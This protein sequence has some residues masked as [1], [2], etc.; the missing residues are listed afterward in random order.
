MMLVAVPMFMRNNHC[1]AVQSF[2]SELYRPTSHTENM[3]KVATNFVGALGILRQP[4]TTH[5]GYR[6]SNGPASSSS[7][8]QRMTG[9]MPHA[10]CW[11]TGDLVARQRMAM[12][13]FSH[14]QSHIKMGSAVV[15]PLGTS[16]GCSGGAWDRRDFKLL[17]NRLRSVGP[18][19][20]SVCT[21]AITSPWS[22]PI[23]KGP[24]SCPVVTCASAH[25]RDVECS[26]MREAFVYEDWCQTMTVP[27]SS[28]LKRKRRLLNRVLTA[29]LCSG[30][31]CRI[32]SACRSQ[33]MSMASSP[34][35]IT[36]REWKEYCT[37]F[38][39]L[40]W[41]LRLRTEPSWKSHTCTSPLRVPAANCGWERD[42]AR[43]MAAA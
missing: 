2:V 19:R 41:P 1:L 42:W 11:D 22:V 14:Q 38:T 9:M 34:Q 30:R 33:T 6:R 31:M 8:Q 20:D 29:V 28:P 24:S 27:L 10:C 17:R 4:Q 5:N 32:D 37:L 25:T 26:C 36:C 12:T 16:E 21:L 23:A 13:T 7:A 18:G 15:A 39:H 35:E 40:V 43:H 3:M